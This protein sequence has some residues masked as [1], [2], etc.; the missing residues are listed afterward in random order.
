MHLGHLLHRQRDHLGSGVP[1]S[2]CAHSADG[3]ARRTDAEFQSPRA[4]AAAS[5]AGEERASRRR[6][7]V[8]TRVRV[9]LYL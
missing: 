7:A 3:G 6:R 2:A 8:A 1:R 4:L 5:R 9:E